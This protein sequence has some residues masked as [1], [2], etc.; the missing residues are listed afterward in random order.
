[1]VLA[2]NGKRNSTKKVNTNIPDQIE[3]TPGVE[4]KLLVAIFFLMAFGLVMIYS[5]SSY[6]CSIRSYCNYDSAF[7]LKSQM[8]YDILSIVV[9]V[10]VT[11]IPIKY[12]RKFGYVFYVISVVIIFLLK[13]PLGLKVNGAL[14]WI[15]VFGVQIQ[16][17][18]IVKVCLIIF[19]A[20]YIC[21][22]WRVINQNNRA[23]DF[24]VF[25][26]WVLFGI[27]SLLLL[28]ISS[29]LSTA[30]IV[31]LMVFVLTL[32]VK[33]SPTMHGITFAIIAIACVI[34][35]V[36]LQNHLP[37]EEELEQHAYHLSRFVGWLNTEQYARTAGYQ[38]LQ[39]LYAIGS[40]GLFGKGLGNGTQKLTNLPEAHNDMIFAV[41]CEELG[42][43]G[44]ILMFVMY[45]YLLYQMYII[46]T[47]C[48]SL[49]GSL[50]VMGVM[51]HF[52][53]QIIVNVCVA[54]NFFPNTGVS[55]P[56]ISSGG[57]SI[58]CNMIEIGMVLGVRRQQVN[59]I[60]QKQG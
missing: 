1:M 28:K 34:G 58:L 9:M 5:A 46:V 53:F 52:T 19:M 38:P 40:G 59:K 22:Y 57:S 44:A 35:L 30:I 60:I 48:R 7:Y 16:I 17:A 2:E 39:S 15:V 47:E 23:S 26:L 25:I 51:L 20:T 18:D 13:T 31:L 56:F 36:Y 55:L 6:Y 43:I 3:L 45:V 14:R 50:I 37:T 24:V 33:K 21:N 32:I 49:F 11:V 8:K 41:I 42:V 29:N 27:Q 54:V 10:I 12:F 4:T